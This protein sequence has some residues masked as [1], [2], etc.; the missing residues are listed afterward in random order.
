MINETKITS[1]NSFIDNIFELSSEK[2]SKNDEK[3]LFWDCP[4]IIELSVNH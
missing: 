4:W 3:T 1:I 2:D